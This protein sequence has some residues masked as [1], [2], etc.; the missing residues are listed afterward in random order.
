LIVV[1]GGAG[2]IGSNLLRALNARGA[3]DILLVDDLNCTAKARN[4]KSCK[5]ADRMDK[6]DFRN[7]L[8]SVGALTNIE[9]IFH[10]GACSDTTATD[11]KYVLD[12]NFTYSKEVLAYC[13]Q[14]KVPLIYASSAAVY[15]V[16]ASFREVPDDESPLNIYAHSKLL[17]DNYLREQW[18]AL[19][20]QVVG[21]RYFNVYGPNEAHKE[22]MAS[23]AYHFFHQYKERGHVRLFEGTDGYGPGQ[24]RRD[25]VC[26][27]DIIDVNLYFFENKELSGIYNVGSGRSQSFNDVA[28]TVINR[29]RE[30]ASQPAMGLHQLVKQ[31][32]IQYIAVPRGL[33]G[34]YQSFTE[35]NL[36]RLRGAGYSAPF[37]SVEEG[38][39]RYVGELL[40]TTG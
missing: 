26:V 27:D 29:L 3:T 7:R 22:R 9:V 14:N 8:K 38:V 35:A 32:T 30:Y 25:F 6:A 28:L 21:L 34:K 16:G 33:Q 37:L 31:G 18:G 2:F 4:V 15:G 5:I 12:N 39:R 19:E 40:K 10:Q 13:L 17:F 1:T 23:V 20:S 11:T 36:T 24:Q